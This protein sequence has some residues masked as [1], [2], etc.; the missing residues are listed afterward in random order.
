MTSKTR[1]LKQA[2]FSRE[3]SFGVRT[4]AVKLAGKEVLGS[5]FTAVHLLA[6]YWLKRVSSKFTA[7]CL[8]ARRWTVHVITPFQS[9]HLG[10]RRKFL[11]RDRTTYSAA[12]AW[13]TVRWSTARTPVALGRK[14]RVRIETN[15]NRELH[16]QLDMAVIHLRHAW[17]DF[18]AP[19]FQDSGASFPGIAWKVP[20]KFRRLP[21]LFALI[22][23]WA[24][25]MTTYSAALA[26]SVTT[27]WSAC[28]KR[29]IMV[30]SKFQLGADIEWHPTVRF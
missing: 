19:N 24:E 16:L 22:L 27:A 5:W 21:C 15:F 8:S 6:I 18:Q 29:W 9:S 3:P 13:S 17:V 4:W 1:A 2:N 30:S 20:E 14:Y 23:R 26:R 7:D 25:S 28:E 12:L 11:N 10:E